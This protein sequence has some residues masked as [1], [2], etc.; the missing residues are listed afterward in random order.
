VS[1]ALFRNHVHAPTRLSRLCVSAFS[2]VTGT[3]SSDLQCIATLA[4]LQ[5]NYGKFN[6]SWHFNARDNGRDNEIV[7]L[8][9]SGSGKSTF[10]ARLISDLTPD[11][12]CR[13]LS[14]D[15]TTTTEVNGVRIGQRAHSSTIAP[16]RYRVGG[17]ISVYDMPVLKD[18]DDVSCGRTSCASRCVVVAFC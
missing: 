3:Q 16:M 12:F 15:A 5:E 13:E 2:T 18:A 6:S 1:F 7:C 11:E 9:V 8:G 14:E 17:G 10:L 4:C